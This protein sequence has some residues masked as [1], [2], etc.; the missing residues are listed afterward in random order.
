MDRSQSNVEVSNAG[1][2]SAVSK[3]GSAEE[4]VSSVKH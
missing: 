3:H 2:L 1:T 4:R